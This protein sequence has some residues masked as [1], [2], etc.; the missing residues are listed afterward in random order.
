MA[1][2][3]GYD[4]GGAH[5]KLALAENDRTIAAAQ[6]PCRL[7]QG[8][9]RLD[10]ALARAAPLVSRAQVHAAT[11][12]GELCEL[13]PDRATGVVEIV[14]RLSALLGPDIRIWMGPRGIG[15]PD[16]ARIDPMCAASTNFLASAELVA[17]RYDEAV[18]IDMGSTTTDIIPVASSRLTPR[19]ITDGE[20]LATGEL[21]YSGLTR[22]D[23]SAVTR[24][25]A[26]R[27]RK[28]RLAAGNF[29]TMADVRRILGELPA[30]VDQH[31]TADGR[32]KSLEESLARFA[33][34]FGRDRRDA[35]LADWRSAARLIAAEQ[36]DDIRL[37]LLMACNV[38]GVAIDAPVIAAG[39][40]VPQIFD[41]ARHVGRPAHPFG[42]IA[43]ATPDCFD[44][45][46]R[47]APAA[48]VALLAEMRT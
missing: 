34:C 37:A 4:V 41:L 13:F 28:Q 5:L 18:L 43:S 6:I 42:E 24:T 2:T 31:D 16:E 25:V 46:T 36:M 14:D 35:N 17:R 8:L 21:V 20:R 30:D 11:M 44:W 33:R 12:T 45:A 9:D 19:A 27:G 1:I 26:F 7:S 10:A 39:I 40:G 22:S 29:A 3:A 32:G 47:C 23:V 38:T 15:T 48:A